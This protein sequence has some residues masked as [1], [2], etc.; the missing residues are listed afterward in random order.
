MKAVISSRTSFL[1]KIWDFKSLIF[2]G[3]YAFLLIASLLEMLAPNSFIQ[4]RPGVRSFRDTRN[5]FWY[6]GAIWQEPLPIKTFSKLPIHNFSIVDWCVFTHIRGVAGFKTLTCGVIQ[7]GDRKIY[8]LESSNIF[9]KDFKV[10]DFRLL[11]PFTA[12]KLPTQETLLMYSDILTPF[13]TSIKTEWDPQK[14]WFWMKFYYGNEPYSLI[15]RQIIGFSDYLFGV[16]GTVIVF[17]LFFFSLAIDTF[18]FLFKLIN[19]FM[20]N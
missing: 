11:G 20:K 4:L 7:N 3:I 8:L 18:V 1:K 10:K 17:L 2:G 13:N 12:S 14:E 19:K 15:G 9:S 5:E 16:Y 6:D